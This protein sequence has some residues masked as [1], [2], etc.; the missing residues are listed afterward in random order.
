MADDSNDQFNMPVTLMYA[1]NLI[2]SLTDA[3]QHLLDSTFRRDWPSLDA[4]TSDAD[5]LSRAW[6]SGKISAELHASFL[7]IA[8]ATRSNE[9]LPQK[10]YDAL[11]S[12]FAFGSRTEL[13]TR[14]ASDDIIG[15]LRIIPDDIWTQEPNYEDVR[16]GTVVFR[17]GRDG[18]TKTHLCF[19]HTWFEWDQLFRLLESL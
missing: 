3:E 19:G 1:L 4:L 11:S 16:D 13:Y 7:K 17:F 6:T 5:K 9:A 12:W 2:G 14:G 15:R 18:H 10:D 8:N